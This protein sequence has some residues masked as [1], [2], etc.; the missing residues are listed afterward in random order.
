MPIMPIESQ[1]KGQ[2]RRIV[3]NMFQTNE[4][5]ISVEYGTTVIVNPE[6]VGQEILDMGKLVP[7]FEARIIDGSISGWI[8]QV[9]EQELDDPLK[10]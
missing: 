8:I 7:V 6:P 9:A 5:H 10:G 4:G 1:I 3:A 2:R